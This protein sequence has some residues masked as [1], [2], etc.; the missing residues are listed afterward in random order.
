MAC[1][2]QRRN[3]SSPVVVKTGEE[4]RSQHSLIYNLNDIFKGD[5]TAMSLGLAL[6]LIHILDIDP[7]RLA[8]LPTRIVGKGREQGAEALP[9]RIVG[10]EQEHDCTDDA[11]GCAS[12]TRGHECMDARVRATQGAVAE[13]S[14]VTAGGRIASGTAI[15]DAEALPTG[16]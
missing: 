11:H 5:K 3:N 14:K 16:M 10:K 13:E 1:V 4:V 9:T 2:N 6:K 7:S 15:E 12:V 8:A